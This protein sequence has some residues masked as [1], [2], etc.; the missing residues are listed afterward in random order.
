MGEDGWRSEDER[1]K[2]S[3]MDVGGDRTRDVGTSAPQMR[4]IGGPEFL[5]ERAG[6][7][8]LAGIFNK[9]SGS[10]VGT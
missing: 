3:S 6:W 1:R 2:D 8:S 9:N 4:T 7:T 10:R 5:E